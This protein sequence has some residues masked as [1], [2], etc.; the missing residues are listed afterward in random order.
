MT[1]QLVIMAINELYDSLEHVR[2]IE[3]QSAIWLQINLPMFGIY[4]TKPLPPTTEQEKYAVTH[5]NKIHKIQNTLLAKTLI[6]I[7]ELE[8]LKER[9]TSDFRK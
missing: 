4:K 6:A 2:H 3:N 7:K 9:G 8:A 5:I 1:N